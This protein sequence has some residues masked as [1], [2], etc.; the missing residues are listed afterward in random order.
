VVKA[1]RALVALLAA[2]VTKIGVESVELIEEI[3]IIMPDNGEE[4]ERS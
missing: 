2:M 1:D 3:M 4:K